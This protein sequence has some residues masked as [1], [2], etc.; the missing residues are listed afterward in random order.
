MVGCQTP[1]TIGYFQDIQPGQGVPSVQ[2]K[3]IT[4]QPGDKATIIVKSKDPEL[5]ELFNLSTVSYRVGQGTNNSYYNGS[6]NVSFYTI[7]SDG[8]IDFPILGK[9]H[10]A[11]LLRGAWRRTGVVHH[12]EL[13][14]RV[15]FDWIVGHRNCG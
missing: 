5:A 7:D 1:K 8:N 9:V 2:P 10:I 3:Y 11:G 13:L 15:G 12:P 4:F 6:Q 14:F